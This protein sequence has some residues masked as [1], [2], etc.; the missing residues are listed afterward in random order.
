VWEAASAILF[1]RGRLYFFRPD[2]TTE[3]NAG[4]GSVLAAYGDLDVEQLKKAARTNKIPGRLV[5][6]IR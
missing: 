6:N 4:H 1:I 2:G 5:E 3:G